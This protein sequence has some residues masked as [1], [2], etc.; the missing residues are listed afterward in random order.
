MEKE[1]KERIKLAEKLKKE[2]QEFEQKEESKLNENKN[3]NEEINKE[4]NLLN[5]WNLSQY[6]NVLINVDWNESEWHYIVV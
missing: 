3:N 6:S 5:D 1:E 4:I 2:E